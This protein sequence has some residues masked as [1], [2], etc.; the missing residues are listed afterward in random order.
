MIRDTYRKRGEQAFVKPTRRIQDQVRNVMELV[1]TR[2]GEYILDAGC[3]S[4]KYCAMISRITKIVGIDSSPAS[5]EV[6]SETVQRFGNPANSAICL[7]EV[8]AIPFQADTFDTVML[9]DIIE[10]LL[11]EDFER[12]LSESYRVLKTGGKLYIYTPSRKHIF[13]YIRRR[14]E[15][16]IALRTRAE[17]VDALTARRFRILGSYHHPAHFPAYREMESMLAH[18]T[19]WELFIKRICMVAMKE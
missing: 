13:E 9:I 4:G 3:G 2:G 8:Q 10:H 1:E 16:H 18:L 14:P 12:G 6:A 15:G 19:G 5:V 17:I 7:A 11:E